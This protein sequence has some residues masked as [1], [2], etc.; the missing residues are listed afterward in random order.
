VKSVLIEK[1]ECKRELEIE[2]PAEDWKKEVENLAAEFSK[3]ARVPGFRPGRVPVGVVKQRFRQEIRSEL[4]KDLLPKAIEKAAEENSVKMITQPDVQDLVFEE[5]KPLTFKAGFEILPALTF[6]EYK[7]L[8]A[9]EEEATVTEDEVMDT[10]SGLQEQAAEFLAVE[11]RLI[12]RGDFASVTFTAYPTRLADEKPEKSFDAKDIL[13]EV[14]G[15]RTVKEF[16]EHLTGKSGGDEIQFSVEYA[17]DFSDKRLAGRRVTYHLKIESIKTKSLPEINDD[18]AKTLGEFGTLAELRDKIRKDLEEGK[19]RR[20][21][22]RT[23]EKLID[24][25]IEKDPFPVPRALV[26]AQI[27]SRLHN[28][29]RSLYRQGVN[30]KQL[31][32]DWEKLREEHRNAAIRDVKATLI[33]EEIAK[34]ESVSVSDEEVDAE[35]AAMAE[36]SHESFSSVKQRLTKEGALDKLRSQLTNQKVLSFLYENADISTVPSPLDKQQTSS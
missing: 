4:L 22:D 33:M 15:E 1:E 11:D 14:G 21:K 20:A 31:S 12:Q 6:S 36:H 27:D 10:L 35:V 16:T 2:I 32:I 18:F 23:C 17:D 19:K 9:E 7:G 8:K 25:M 28:M 26:E 3:V 30:P 24:Q 5:D 13:V 34:L 29:I